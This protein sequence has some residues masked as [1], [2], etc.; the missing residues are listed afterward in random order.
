MI[1]PLTRIA[2]SKVIISVSPLLDIDHTDNGSGFQVH[3]E[4]ITPF[5]A[6]SEIL[7]SLISMQVD[8]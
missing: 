2:S 7:A 3:P 6:K 1:L 5:Y 4:S 8:S